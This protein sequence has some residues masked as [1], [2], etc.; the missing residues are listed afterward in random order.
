MAATALLNGV[1]KPRAIKVRE[2]KKHVELDPP[3]DEAPV[4]PEVIE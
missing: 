2:A 1:M 4:E 3:V